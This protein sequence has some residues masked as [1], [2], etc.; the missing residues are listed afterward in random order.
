MKFSNVV[1][2]QPKEGEFDN[3]VA[4]ASEPMDAE[5]ILQNI[6]I[7]TSNNT[8]CFIGIWESEEHIAKAR[9][10]MIAQLDK[11]RDKLEVLS[12]ELGVTDPVSGPIIFEH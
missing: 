1:R 6:I 11:V 9:P 4:I 3:V 5:G 7:K 12:E 2:M 8:L 10:K